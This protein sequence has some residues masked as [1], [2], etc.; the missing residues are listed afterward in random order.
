MRRFSVLLAT[1]V[2]VAIV[3]RAAAQSTHLVI[4]KDFAFEPQ[5]VVAAPGD[6]IHWVWESGFHTVTSGVGCSPDGWFHAPVDQFNPV[7]EWIVPS[8]EVQPGQVINYVCLP[9]CV[10]MTGT[11]TV[12]EDG[13]SGDLNGDGVVDV[14]DLLILL[15]AWGPCP[16]SGDC[17][18]DLNGDGAVDVSDLL[19]LLA[20]WG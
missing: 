10:H 6:T 11:I 15:A 3:P 9:H 8:E 16:Q 20:N 13:A 5:H 2:A 19:I 18:A 4:V 17:I 12:L 14:S 1:A 7:F